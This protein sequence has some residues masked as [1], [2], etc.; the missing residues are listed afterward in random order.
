[1]RQAACIA[2][3]PLLSFGTCIGKFTKTKK[4]HIHITALDYLAPY[5]K[6]RRVLPFLYLFSIVF[7]SSPMLNSNFFTVTTF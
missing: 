7:G 1:M 4:F 6:V 3:E 5:A 2:R